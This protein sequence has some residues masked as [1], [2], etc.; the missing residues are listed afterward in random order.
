MVMTLVKTSL[1]YGSVQFLKSVTLFRLPPP[2]PPTERLLQ[3]LEA[4]Y[5]PPSHDRPR[6]AEGWEMIGL[7][8]WSKAKAAAVKKKADDIEA[9]ERER[10]PTASPDPYAGSGSSTPEKRGRS[11]PERS[12]RRSSR[13][14]RSRSRTR[15]RSRGSTPEK[16]T[17]SR[18]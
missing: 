1:T 16:R 14:S 17:V 9:G 18:R 2:T 6:D 3:A 12:S 7:Y 13:R 11:S 4:F 10:S 5:A 15:S 8:E